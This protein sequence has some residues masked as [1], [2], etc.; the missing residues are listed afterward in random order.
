MPA[1]ICSDQTACCTAAAAGSAVTWVFS[2]IIGE[3][4]YVTDC[5]MHL[6]VCTYMQ[7]LYVLV[8][9]YVSQLSATTGGLQ[10]V[11]AAYFCRSPQ[12][13]LQPQLSQQAPSRW[14]L[15]KFPVPTTD[16]RQVQGTQHRL[17]MCHKQRHNN[18]SSSSSSS[19]RVEQ[20]VTCL[21][22]QALSRS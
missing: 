7:V 20:A 10:H 1:D 18:G 4:L 19:S 21:R 16:K 12:S 13:S 17:G 22:V 11:S 6:H 3:T 14:H 8:W 5:L 9:L 2:S 15:H